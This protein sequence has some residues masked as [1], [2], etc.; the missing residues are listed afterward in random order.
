MY[1]L[2]ENQRINLI[3][4]KISINDNTFSSALKRNGHIWYDLSQNY[5]N[6]VAIQILYRLQ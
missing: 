5:T 3:K 1:N 6:F 4:S 2:L